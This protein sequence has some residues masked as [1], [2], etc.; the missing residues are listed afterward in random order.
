M[1]LLDAR[2]VLEDEPY[3]F[4]STLVHELGHAFGLP[5]VDAWGDDMDGCESIMS[6]NPR[7]CVRGAHAP[8]PEAVLLPEEYAL[9][10]ANEVAFPGFAFDP[11]VHN[12]SGAPLRKSR[13]R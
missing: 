7:H 8:E 3:C 10:G 2:C 9:L 6:Y 5:H 12:P 13:E 11:A 1:A 4:Q